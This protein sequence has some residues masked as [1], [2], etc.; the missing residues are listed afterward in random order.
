MA[1]NFKRLG[2]PCAPGAAYT[3]LYTVPASKMSVV[4]VHICNRSSSV[5]QHR[6][7]L[8]SDGEATN[9][10]PNANFLSYDNDLQANIP[11]QITGIAM[12]T[13]YRIVVYGSDANVSFSAWGD[14]MDA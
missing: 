11:Q 1:D 14:E 7:A 9:P 12:G 3:V 4:T 5:K 8:V 13:G 6:V 2:T 10:P